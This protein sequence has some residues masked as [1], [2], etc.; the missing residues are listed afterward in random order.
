MKEKECEK[1]IRIADNKE[2]FVISFYGDFSPILASS[3][4]RYLRNLKDV[5]D[6][7]NRFKKA[8]SKDKNLLDFIEPSHNE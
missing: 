1:F 4:K 7:K 3:Q 6:F 5:R 2:F 8:E